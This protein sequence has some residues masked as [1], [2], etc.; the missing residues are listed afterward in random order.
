M[1]EKVT[2]ADEYVKTA[3]AQCVLAKPAEF[4]GKWA[5][6]Q[7]KLKDMGMEEAGVELSAII[8]EKMKLWGVK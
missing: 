5:E 1:N 2:A 6:L 7:K 8:G 3:L 4:D